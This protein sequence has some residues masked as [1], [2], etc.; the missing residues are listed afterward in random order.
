MVVYNPC[1]CD[2]FYS[3]Q[4]ARKR[5]R[6]DVEAEVKERDDDGEEVLPNNFKSRFISDVE[7]EENVE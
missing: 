4:V 1:E 3:L 2:V 6:R 7:E 5:K